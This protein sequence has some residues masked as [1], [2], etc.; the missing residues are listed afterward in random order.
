M[1]EPHVKHEKLVSMS[2]EHREIADG[3]H[4]EYEPKRFF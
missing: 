4:I 3:A 1:L 2:P